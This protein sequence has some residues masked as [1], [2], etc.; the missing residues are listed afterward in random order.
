M[1]VLFGGCDLIYNPE[2]TSE[3]SNFNYKIKVGIRQP[4]PNV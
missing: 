3:T 4:I 2:V 1:C